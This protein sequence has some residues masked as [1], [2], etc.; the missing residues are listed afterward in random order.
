VA[1][2]QEQ[3]LVVLYNTPRSEEIRI[4]RSLKLIAEKLPTARLLIGKMIH[5]IE[6]GTRGGAIYLD[7]DLSGVVEIPAGME[8][9]S[10]AWLA[11]YL[12][13]AAHRIQKVRKG[14]LGGELTD[15]IS[16]LRKAAEALKQLGG[17]KEEIAAELETIRQ[18]QY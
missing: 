6:S 8:S 2:I 13:Y 15:R 5:R 1:P 7:R 12:L 9:R 3:P 16:D 11:S 10:E 4:R 18:L 14:E 17:A